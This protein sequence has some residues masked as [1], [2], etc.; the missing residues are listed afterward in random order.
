MIIKRVTKRAGDTFPLF[1]RWTSWLAGESEQ[2]GT[3]V[4]IATVT[5]S[6][7]GGITILGSP[8]PTLIGDVARVWVS[9]GTPSGTPSL[10]RCTITTTQ[11]HTVSRSIA[12]TVRA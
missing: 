4:T 10:V 5:W 8:P 6:V 2:L 3:T 9:S 11:G 1:M 7:E 12:V